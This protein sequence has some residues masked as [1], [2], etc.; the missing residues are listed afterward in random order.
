M[1]CLL[2]MKF[3]DGLGGDDVLQQPLAQSLDLVLKSVE[4][5]VSQ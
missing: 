2:M 5:F 4:L 1:S 3:D